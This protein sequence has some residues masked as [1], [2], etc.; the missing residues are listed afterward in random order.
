MNYLLLQVH[1]DDPLG[2]IELDSRP[3]FFLLPFDGEFKAQIKE[4]H[5]EVC[6]LS[7]KYGAHRIDHL[8]FF[9]YGGTYLLGD[10]E[11]YEVREKM[12]CP[13]FS[14]DGDLPNEVFTNANTSDLDLEFPAIKLS[15]HGFYFEVYQ[16]GVKLMTEGLDYAHIGLSQEA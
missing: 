2:V 15:K 4:W 13:D 14:F 16:D 3:E 12:E 11:L 10:D 5:E 7:A 9:Y 1:V 6:Y 8:N